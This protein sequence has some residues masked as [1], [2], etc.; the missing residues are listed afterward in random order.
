MNGENNI[1]EKDLQWVKDVLFDLWD[2]DKLSVS[3]VVSLILSLE[4]KNIE[5]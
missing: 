1:A 2:D 5:K 4:K 3:E